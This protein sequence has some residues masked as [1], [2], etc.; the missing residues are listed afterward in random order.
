MVASKPPST[1]F[2]KNMR[3]GYLFTNRKDSLSDATDEQFEKLPSELTSDDIY[4]KGM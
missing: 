4:N 3:A 2:C 1:P